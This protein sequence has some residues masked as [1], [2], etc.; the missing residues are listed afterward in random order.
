MR[1]NA[2]A[3]D[4]AV[5]GLVC[6]LLIVA[7]LIA[8]FYLLTLQKALSRVSR[9]NRL[10]EPGMVWLSL[11]PLF[12]IVWNFFIVTRIPDSLRNEFRDRGQD[13]GSDYGKGIGLTNAIIGVASIP[14]SVMRNVSEAAKQLELTMVFALI[15][16]VLGLVSLVLF[17]IFWVR[18]AGYSKQLAALPSYSDDGPEYNSG[19]DDRD[20]SPGGPSSDAIRP[21]DPGIFR[22]EDRDRY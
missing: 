15:E 19:D 6:L 18:I 1:P 13:D 9:R 11:I 8:V 22:P 20:R 4:T 14:L 16:G 12:N 3:V 7:I 17:I 10:M 21:A 2:A 5:L